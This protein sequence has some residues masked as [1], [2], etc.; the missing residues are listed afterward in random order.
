MEQPQAPIQENADIKENENR[1]YKLRN[2]GKCLSEGVSLLTEN[3]RRMLFLSLP[4]CIPYALSTAIVVQMSTYLV[5]ST[6]TQTIAFFVVSGILSIL[7]FI[8]MLALVYRFIEIRADDGSLKPQTFKSIYNRNFISLALKALF[9]FAI[10]LMLVGIVIVALYLYSKIGTKDMDLDKTILKL[11]GLVLV[12]LVFIIFGIA[13]NNVLPTLMLQKGNYFKATFDGLKNGFWKW[14]KMMQISVLVYLLET[15][16]L[17]LLSA[18]SIVF[19]F[20]QSS[21]LTSQLNG[22]AV[23]LPE[24]FKTWMFITLLVTQFA[25]FFIQMIYYTPMSFTYASI[26]T[27]EKEAKGDIPLV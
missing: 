25:T 12:V 14:G 23:N 19:T 3:F 1:F 9:F 15:V 27:E 4:V 24:N 5:A 22:D 20:V 13:Y 26:K 10:T 11:I 6:S 2:T 18:P 17:F 7:C 21:A 16:V 8:G